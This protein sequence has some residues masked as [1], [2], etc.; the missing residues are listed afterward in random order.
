MTIS[1][2]PTGDFLDGARLQSTRTCLR[3]PS[4]GDEAGC[5]QYLEVLGDRRLCQLERLHQFIDGRLTLRET[6]QNGAAGRIGESGKHRAE[7]ILHH[8]FLTSYIHY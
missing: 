2:D 3:R 1:V 5:L 4:P 7:M 6:R 8:I